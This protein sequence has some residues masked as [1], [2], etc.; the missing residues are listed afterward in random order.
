MRST[1][2]IY[3]VD[4]AAQRIPKGDTAYSFRDANVIQMIAAVDPDPANDERMNA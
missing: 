2:H 3:A 1:M 4:G